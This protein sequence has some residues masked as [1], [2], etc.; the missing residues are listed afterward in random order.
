MIC[1]LM[2]RPPP[3]STRTY[4]LFPYTTLFRSTVPRIRRGEIHHRDRDRR[5]RRPDRE[6]RLSFPS[7]PFPSHSPFDRLRVR[8]SQSQRL[9]M[10]SLSKHETIETP[11]PTLRRVGTGPM[12]MS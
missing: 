8:A 9:L 11:N 6:M 3:K 4:T 10:L 2:I 1:V 5:R 7:R 12:K